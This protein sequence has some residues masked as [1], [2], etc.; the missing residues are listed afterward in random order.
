MRKYLLPKEGNFY[1]SKFKHFSYSFKLIV[2]CTKYDCCVCI[3][4]FSHLAGYK[5]FIDK[6]V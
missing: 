4:C 1:T 6:F 5:S 3:F 2:V